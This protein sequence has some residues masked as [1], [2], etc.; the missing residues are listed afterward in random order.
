MSDIPKMIK[1]TISFICL[2]AIQSYTK[3]FFITVHF[4]SITYIHIFLLVIFLFLLKQNPLIWN[5][6]KNEVCN[7]LCKFHITP[8]YLC[9][10]RTLTPLPPKSK[11][12]H[13][14]DPSD[15][16]IRHWHP[17]KSSR[18]KI[19]NSQWSIFSSSINIYFDYIISN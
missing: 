13:S 7:I 16:L 1:F 4:Q 9:K 5:P 15:R 10:N 11:E 19:F 18:W 6:T 2:I 12:P 8:L 14:W 17:M 3:Y